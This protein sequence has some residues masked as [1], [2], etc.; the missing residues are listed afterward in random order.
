MQSRINNYLNINEVEV[1][2]YIDNN[3]L[4]WGEQIGGRG[5]YS[6]KDKLSDNSYDAI[7]LGSVYFAPLMKKQ[8]LDVN[9]DYKNKIFLFWDEESLKEAF[10]DPNLYI[11]IDEIK[12]MYREPENMENI[13]RK[14]CEQLPEMA[15]VGNYSVL[16]EENHDGWWKKEG[17]LVA[18]AGGGYVKGEKLQYT[19]SKESFYESYA[20]GFKYIEADIIETTDGKLVACAWFRP[21]YDQEQATYIQFLESCEVRNYTPFEFTDLIDFMIKYSDVHIVLDIKSR[22][23]EHYKLMLSEIVSLVEEDY[24]LQRFVIQVHEVQTLRIARSVYP[25]KDITLTLYRTHWDGLLQPNELAKLCAENEIPVVTMGIEKMNY[26]YLRFFI[27]RNIRI[28]IH[29]IDTLA[30]LKKG[31][32]LGVDSFITNWL[33]PR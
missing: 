2:G 7:L 11:S 25:F 9:N 20:N 12:W 15:Q 10:F 4:L 6:P 27:A 29:P 13:F 16:S 19:N 5:I 24:I 3:A 18:H 17:K 21:Y 33:L 32:Y 22:T 31:E 1:C 30:D 28:C 14:I 23:I 26:E 8:I